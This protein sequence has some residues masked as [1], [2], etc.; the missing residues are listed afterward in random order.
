MNY[1]HAFHA[2]N[3]GD[4]VKHAVLVLVLRALAD[5]PKPFA[6]L[7]SHAG[8]GAYDLG[9]TEAL[10]TGEARHGILRLLA[11]DDPPPL[12]RPY[13]D[14]VRRF[15]PT[16]AG[17]GG[18][19]RCYPGSPRLA[20]AVLRRGDRLVLVELH[21]EDAARLG[22]EFRGD[23]QVAV[24]RRDG[25]EALRALVPPKERRGLVLIDPPFEVPGEAERLIRGLAALH[26]LWP[27]GCVLAWYPIKD[28]GPADRLRAGLAATGIP[29]MLA[30]EL[31]V[32][33][34]LDPTRLNGCGLILVNPPWR[35][36]DQIAEL[37]PALQP[38]L[39]RD[40]GGGTS[41]DWLTAPPS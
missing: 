18:E 12:A 25:Y 37:L 19:P 1:R 8:I 2:G 41:L 26:R 16:G 14:L 27:T 28:R 13:L 30:A 5:K 38:I 15:G 11:A 40:A 6:V 17:A 33:S 3:F 20:R 22:A 21:P 10:K 31:T 24:H 35:L 34:V 32:W 29:R 23:A 39:A 4:V 7:D 9:G 36:P